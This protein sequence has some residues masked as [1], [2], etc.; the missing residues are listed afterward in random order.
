VAAAVIPP[1]G[2][3]GNTA[4]FSSP[5]PATSMST[6]TPAGPAAATNFSAAT[7]R[8]PPATKKRGRRQATKIYSSR[9]SISEK[10]DELVGAI[11][12]NVRSFAGDDCE[13]S[14]RGEQIFNL[15]IKKI[16]DCKM[17]RSSDTDTRIG[18]DKLISPFTLMENLYANM[19]ILGMEPRQSKFHLQ[20]KAQVILL[21]VGIIVLPNTP[22]KLQE[23]RNI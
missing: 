10:V 5:P 9:N 15:A 11:L 3:H 1:P 12:G 13:N 17:I 16:H 19:A 6:V 4:V 21:G 18:H 23:L 8:N 22:H 20:V 7:S 14:P 2:I